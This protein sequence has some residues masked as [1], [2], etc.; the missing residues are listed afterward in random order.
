LVIGDI[1]GK[2]FA[3]ALLMAS[4]QASLRSQCAIALDEPERVLRSVNQMFY[5]NTVESAYATLFFAEYCDTSQRLRYVNCG[6]LS[7]LLLRRDDSVERL[8]ST[9]TVLGIF[10]DWDCEVAQQRMTSG[11]ILALYTDG[12]T[13]TFNDREE[14]F[15]EH[16]LIAALRR[17]R[18]LPAQASIAAIVEEVQRFG[19]REQQDDITLIIAKCREGIPLQ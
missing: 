1:A 14:D 16:R 19:T 5:E 13:E 3:A 7:A 18:E 15:G 12:I 11:D 2:G 6:H 9:S 4:L 8:A 17:H 10:E